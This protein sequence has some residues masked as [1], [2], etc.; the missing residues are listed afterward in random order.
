MK[1][2]VTGAA[3]FI[4]SNLVDRLLAAEHQVTGFDN[5]S[6]GFRPFLQSA[7]QSP[8]FRLVEGDLLDRDAV[9]RAMDGS[10]FVFHLAANADVSDGDAIIGA[11]HASGGGRLI[12]AVD[13]RFE[14]IR[15]GDDRGGGG[16]FLQKRTSSLI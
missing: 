8:R 11:H 14:R 12:L 7:C 15:G 10:D 1:A 13:R 4:G 16:G 9:T 5:F 2:L 6:A 3:G